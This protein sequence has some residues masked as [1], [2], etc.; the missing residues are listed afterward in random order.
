MESAESCCRPNLFV[1]YSTV[2]S[3]S[4]KSVVRMCCRCSKVPMCGVQASRL[5]V[6]AVVVRV[7]GGRT[8]VSCWRRT[9]ATLLVP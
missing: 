8:V 9:A 2:N 5:G 7:R 1:R 4:E 3:L 6:R